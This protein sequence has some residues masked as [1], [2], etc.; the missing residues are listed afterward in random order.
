MVPILL[1]PVLTVGMGYAAVSLIGEATRQPAKIMILGGEDSPAVVE[2]L[3]N[4]KNLIVRSGVRRL[5]QPDFQQKNS[6]GG[7]DSARDWPA[8]GD[9]KT[10]V[11]IYIYAGD[12]KSASAASRIEKFFTEYRDRMARERLAWRSCPLPC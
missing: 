4:T 8:E 2:G 7:G 11:K 6:R 5:Y 9:G 3:K 1:F 12:L 10:T